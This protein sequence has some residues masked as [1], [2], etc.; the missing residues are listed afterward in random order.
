MILIQILLLT[1][2]LTH[3]EP[4][5]NGIAVLT[6]K[7]AKNKPLI[8]LLGALVCWECLSFWTTFIVTQDIFQAVSVAFVANFIGLI[9]D[10][11]DA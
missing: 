6:I 11:L 7:A 1:W 10:K 5:I 8:I 4:I 2:F 3:F 9:E